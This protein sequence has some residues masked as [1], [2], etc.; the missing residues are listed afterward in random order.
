MF[1]D[2]WSVKEENVTLKQWRI[3]VN[4]ATGLKFTKFTASKS[5]M[6]EPTLC[7]LQDLKEDGRKV[8]FIRC[9]NGGENQ[10]LKERCDSAEWKMG[11]KFEFTARNTPQQNH[12]AELGLT[13]IAN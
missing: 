3:M 10:K 13:T 9:D 4:E 2:M 11:I 6:V 8:S 5:G 1:L 7:L 12:L